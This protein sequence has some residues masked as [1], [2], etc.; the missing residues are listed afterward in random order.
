MKEGVPSCYLFFSL[1][2]SPLPVV[3]LEVVLVRPPPLRVGGGDKVELTV[4][5]RGGE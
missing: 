3:I 4:G 5:A 2:A 1:Q